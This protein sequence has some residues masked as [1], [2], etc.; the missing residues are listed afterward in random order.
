MI[1]FKKNHKITLYSAVIT[2]S[3]VENAHNK[4][5]AVAAWFWRG[6]PDYYYDLFELGVDVIITDYP[7]RVSNQLKEYKADKIYLEG[8]ENIEKNI[9]N[10]S[11]CSSCKNGYVLIKLPEEEKSLCKIKYELDP[12]FYATDLFGIYHRKNIYSIQIYNSPFGDF[13]LCQKNKKNIFYFEWKF[14]LYDYDGTN[15][16]INSKLNYDHLTDKNIKN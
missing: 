16:K 14:D 13:S 5:M 8:C 12:D 10:I 6:D 1:N 15:Y 2:K 9:D 4:G 3:L 11:T 7:L